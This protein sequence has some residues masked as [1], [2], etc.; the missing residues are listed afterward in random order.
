MPDGDTALIIAA[1]GLP[2]DLVEMPP[3]RIEIEI[4]VK[5][6]ID[7]EGLREIEQFFQVRDRIGV[8]VRATADQIPAIAQRRAVRC[9]GRSRHA[10]ASAWCRERWRAPAHERRAHK[11]PRP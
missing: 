4:K 8:H 11:Y 5:I 3:G 6:D 1:L 2:A 9:G 10:S 7:I